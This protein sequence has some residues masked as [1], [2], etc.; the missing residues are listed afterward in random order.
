MRLGKTYWHLRV[1]ETKIYSEIESLYEG[2]EHGN[3]EKLRF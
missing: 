2:G 3:M 1:N